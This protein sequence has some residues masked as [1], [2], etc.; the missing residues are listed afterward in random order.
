MAK[1]NVYIK[2]GLWK[3][4]DKPVK[5]ELSLDSVVDTI[6]SSGVPAAIPSTSYTVTGGTLPLVRISNY[7]SGSNNFDTTGTVPV[8]FNYGQYIQLTANNTVNFFEVDTISF[9][10][11]YIVGF[12]ALFDGTSS[13]AQCTSISFPNLKKIL[14]ASIDN[15]TNGILIRSVSVQYVSLPLLN[16]GYVAVQNSPT[17]VEVD[18]SSMVD[19][20]ICALGIDDSDIPLSGIIRNSSFSNINFYSCTNIPTISLDVVDVYTQVSYSNTVTVSF[21]NAVNYHQDV[22]FAS[23]NNLANV[24]L[25]SIGTI[26][27][28]KGNVTLPNG[29]LT[30]ESVTH[31][32]DVL[33]SLDGTN[34]TTLWGPDVQLNISGGTNAVPS[35]EDLVKIGVLEGRGATVNYNS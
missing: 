14:Y 6:V 26:K 13:P 30:S 31:V 2:S 33:I 21:P 1:S 3:N 24:N 4:T 7:I 15:G 28:I 9:A 32:L 11:E 29:A 19:N 27:K 8:E 10:S 17:L 22:Y 5:G 12:D 16:Q 20:T 34:G 23:C 18:I 35:A 25:G